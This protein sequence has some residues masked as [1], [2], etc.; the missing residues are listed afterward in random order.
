[1]TWNEIVSFV[2]IGLSAIIF[3]ISLQA[4]TKRK[5]LVIQLF[6]SILYFLSYMVVISIIPSAIIG[7]FTAIFELV[8]IIVFYFIDKSE[9]FNTKKINLIA[10]LSFCIVLTVCTILAWSGWYSLCPLIGAILVSLA[11]GNKNMVF[12]KLSYIIQSLLIIT[13]LSFMHLWVNAL[14]QCVVF[15]FGIV[16]LITFLNKKNDTCAK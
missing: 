7:A 5:I 4:K 15:V 12:V 3:S 6:A 1:M 2:C 14:T 16:G 8:R 10:S 11:L 9:K 13:Y